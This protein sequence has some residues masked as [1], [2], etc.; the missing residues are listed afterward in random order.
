MWQIGDCS[1]LLISAGSLLGSVL[2][3]KEGLSGLVELEGGDLAV[4]GVDGDGHLLSVL[5]VSH[6]L[7]DVDAPLLSENGLDLTR[8]ALHAGFDATLLDQDGV[9]LSHGD[10]SGIVLASELLAEVAAH[11]LSS[12]AAG[13]GEM[14]LSGLS[15][16]ARNTYA[17]LCQPKSVHLL[18]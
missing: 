17:S 1:V 2:S 14:S 11:N 5:L 18:V 4:R 13:G 8:L 6:D 12:D 16:L 7:L 9:A 10:G 3:L 15:S